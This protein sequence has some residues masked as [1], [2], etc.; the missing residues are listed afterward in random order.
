MKAIRVHEF[1]PPGVMKFDDI[2]DPQ[3][4]AKQLVVRVK[5]AGVNPVDT[6]IRA[7]TY[8]K[9]PA[10]PYT[11]GF[12]AAGVVESVGPDVRRFKPG[13]RVYINHNITGAYAEKTVC[14]EDSAFA[15]P[16][17][18]SFAQGAG[19]WVPYATAHY[20]L[21]EAA[22]AK[23][24]ETL[25]VH[26]ASGG[27]GSAALQTARAWGMRIIG[28]A[29]TDKGLSLV[30]EQGGVALNH[31][32][33]NYPE[34]VGAAT[35]GAGPDVILEMLA[36]V[37]LAKDL[38]MIGRGGRIVIIGNRGTIEINPRD[39]MGKGASIIGMLLLN[40]RPDETRRMASALAAGLENGTLNPIVGKEFPLS[41][42]A[43]AHEAV[44]APGAFGKIVLIP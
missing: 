34:Q 40:A 24:G 32:D 30:R 21:F 14:E 3:A 26:G 13:D 20:A 8:A 42:A 11:P 7:G 38:A 4:G 5:A 1:G 29:G 36:N 19:V 17:R 10:L 44:L 18:M 15:L 16:D 12:D 35:N 43:R 41:D 25:L 22:K 6:Y 33:P 9:K 27:V 39:A 31:H 23:P 28:T 2:A 37:N